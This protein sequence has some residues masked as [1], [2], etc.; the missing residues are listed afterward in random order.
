MASSDPEDRAQSRFS[1]VGMWKD[2]R[3]VF[4][5]GGGNRYTT[6]SGGIGGNLPKDMLYAKQQHA[7]NGLN[8]MS[9]TM[10]SKAKLKMWQNDFRDL[11]LEKLKENFHPENYKRMR[12]MVHTSSNTLQRVVSELSVMYENPSRR[13]LAV[14]ETQEQT[15][16]GKTGA[17]LKDK[18]DIK[19]Q[20]PETPVFGDDEVNN[21]ATMLQLS[22]VD[23]TPNEETPFERWLKAKD[24]DTLLENVENLAS[25][26]PA[27]WVRPYVRYSRYVSSERID[28]KGETVVDTVPDLNSG[29]LSYIVYT[30]DIADIVPDPQ[31]PTK[32]LAFWYWTDEVN[33]KGEP[34]RMVNYW[35][36][37]TYFKMSEDW[38]TT[39]MVVPHNLERLPVTLFQVGMPINGYYLDGTGDDL[40]E[41]TLELCVLKTIQNARVR[42]TGFKQLVI[43][44]GS[45][46]DTPADQ[47][48]GGP[49]PIYA[50]DGQ[51]ATVLDMQPELKPFTELCSDRG[52]ELAA[53][54]GISSAEYKAEGNPQSGFAKKLDRE[55]VLKES[56]RRRKYFAQSEQDL[57]SLV[58]KVL[59]SEPLPMIGVLDPTAKME[60]DFAEPT[61]EEDPKV[62]AQIDAL[63]LRMNTQS[64]LDVL[65][66]KNPDLNDTELL[67]QAL[68][69]REINKVFM[70]EDQLRLVDV[71][72]SRGEKPSDEEAED[73]A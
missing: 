32:A 6:S 4:S 52:L 63:E 37:N 16:S 46:E 30:P 40:F 45:A 15:E 23:E 25:F 34:V 69:N 11:V 7:S 22:G 43:T 29:T 38:Q 41:G 73:G 17:T 20:A 44:G 2:L 57:Y 59:Q 61:F 58:A 48:M 36:T 56:R 31:D 8:A 65:R 28:E 5:S 71:L 68:R 50:P 13:A 9:R 64:I 66:R 51:T 53:K 42:D 18:P 49:T 3:S 14:D 27:V 1:L 54:Y 19:E 12:L 62:Q 24:L 70:S 33:A 60:I 39:H 10:K 26:L 35:N 55:K 67:Q 21:L 47:V 72:S